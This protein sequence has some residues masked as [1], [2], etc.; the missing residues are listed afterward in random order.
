MNKPFLLIVLFVFVSATVF[1]QTYTTPNTGVTWTLDDIAA[2]SP[3]TVQGSGTTYTLSENLVIAQND[4]VVI[5]GE[6]TLSIEADLL[7]TVF[8]GLTV[9]TG[10]VTINAVTP[11]APYEGFRFEEGSAISFSNATITRGGGL[12]VLTENFSIDSCTL[13]ENVEGA[14]TGGVISLSRGMPQIT[15]NTIT[16]NQLPAISS[17]AN[18]EVSPNIFNNY[19]EG[20]N[21]ENSN[22]PQINLGITRPNDTL[23][24]V[25]NTILGDRNLD[26]VGGIA[27]ANFLGG[28][29]QILAVI[30]GNTI[31][32]NR[33]GMT[34]LGN[35]SFA[36][37]RDN[38]IENNDTQG[39]PNLGGSG[40]S[41]N[42][43]SGPMEV[44]ASG[45]AFRRNLWGI[46]LIDEASINLGD[47]GDNPGN[48]VFSEN[49][50]NNETYALY[51]NTAN[52]ILAKNNCWI[53]NDPPNTLADAEAVIF[54][55]VDDPTLGEVLF[56][57]VSCALL[58][59]N[60]TEGKRMVL[61]PNPAKNFI[62]FY[63]PGTYSGLTV[64]NL[65]GQE[66]LQA[67]ITSGNNFFQFNL[68]AGMYIVVFT[69]SEAKVLEKLVVQ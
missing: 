59:I 9:S 21:Q 11:A 6:L 44:I 35:N 69:G 56:D 41:L 24:I 20:N 46:T 28:S 60:T 26:M 45:N 18:N 22:R 13:T 17:G 68:P 12:R 63:N 48:N 36:Y 65:S 27:V 10:P 55:Q 32:D 39:N 34:I 3:T 5:D 38:V 47:D 7:I 50:N 66:V 33:Y 64:Y 30:D 57:P 31:T 4:A 52:T 53:E 8:G 23:R 40:I 62:Q 37:V 67:E 2:A 49:G 43:A 1:S 25:Q 19:I 14:T 58:N 54:H 15:N 29:G 61:S 42:T 16:F 51:N